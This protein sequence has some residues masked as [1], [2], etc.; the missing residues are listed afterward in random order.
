MLNNN[1]NLAK[2]IITIYSDGACKGNPGKGGWGAV[3]IAG[4]YQKHISGFVDNTTNNRMELTAVIE[5]LKT[6]KKPSVIT[7]YSDS[8]YLKDGITIWIHQ[9]K[10]NGWKNNKKQPVKNIDLWQELE[11]VAKNHQI[12]W[13]WV[14][15]HNG[16]YFNEIADSLASNAAITM[17][18]V[19]KIINS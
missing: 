17:Q 5:S 1:T 15:A 8:S 9:W 18:N 3:L 6:I 12:D 7:I 11:I 2:P 4:K 14:K 19:L 13:Q 10:V 16:N